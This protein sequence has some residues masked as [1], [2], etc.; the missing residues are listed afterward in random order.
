VTPAEDCSNGIDDDF[1]GKDDC[2]DT[3]CTGQSA[4]PIGE[5]CSNGIDDDGDG[6]TDCDDAECGTLGI[7]SGEVCTVPNG[8]PTLTCGSVL[9]GESNDQA[10][11]TNVITS[12]EC[13]DPTGSD[14]VGFIDEIGPEYAYRFEVATP[15]KVTLT[16]NN[17][18]GDH[19]I[20][21]IREISGQCDSH[22]GCIA[23]GGNG[24]NTAEVITFAAYP[25]VTYYIVVD[26]Y[27]GNVATYDLSIACAATGF[28]NC[29]NGSDDDGDGKIDCAD[30]ECWG[31]AGCTT[32]QNCN[33]GQDDD[34]DGAA[35]CADED[36]DGTLAC[37]PGMG[38]WQ[39]FQKTTTAEVV[40][41]A[42]Y[43][44]HFTV[45][46]TDPQGYTWEATP[47]ANPTAYPIAPGAGT[48][49][50]AD[51][52]NSLV[53]L[54]FSFPFQGQSFTAAYVTD[55][56]Y[57]SFV[58]EKAQYPGPGGWNVYQAPRIA[59]LW[60]DYDPAEGGT[61]TADKYADHVV[62]TWD[63][64]KLYSAGVTPNRFQLVLWDSGDVTMSW[65]QIDTLDNLPSHISGF[66]AMVGARIGQP[67]VQT[68]FI[69]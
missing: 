46:G 64:V 45:D 68:D 30:P 59:P 37:S 12:A 9:T 6:K 65:L 16:V 47:L 24:A 31:A 42:G 7:C 51:E 33:D 32:E 4:C 60:A 17:F 63:G 18:T 28:E 23:Y 3:E 2:S 49:T 26:G 22:R 48:L 27:Q 1:D 53:Q 38:Y 69:P 10:G 44:I 41:L 25:D 56:G 11:S 15:Q 39:L 20:Y 57:I 8:E 21:V 66:V 58:N 34:L 14:P 54:G 5:N 36:C 35:D 55:D 19:D 52:A 67:P 29:S 50:I 13:L 40:D 62:F 61:V 43:S